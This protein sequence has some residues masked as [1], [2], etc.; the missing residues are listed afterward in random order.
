MPKGGIYIPA[1]LK[2]RA[3]GP[4][5]VH[6]VRPWM[7]R[8]KRL[9][10]QIYNWGDNGGKGISSLE[11]PCGM[12][13]SPALSPT[14]TSS[15]IIVFSRAIE[16]MSNV[17][18]RLCSTWRIPRTEV[19]TSPP[20]VSVPAK[21]VTLSRHAHIWLGTFPDRILFATLH[22]PA[23]SPPPPKARKAWPEHGKIRAFRS[24]RKP[25]TLCL[26][27][28]AAGTCPH[29]KRWNLLCK[30]VSVVPVISRVRVDFTSDFNPFTKGSITGFVTWSTWPPPGLGRSTADW[31]AR[32]QSPE[33]TE[34]TRLKKKK[35]TVV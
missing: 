34:W 4:V 12:F 5:T 23:S 30:S 31:E 3:G 7:K 24:R 9:F 20:T 29:W 26:S 6:T 28:N 2:P 8:C 14:A 19:T 21:A 22:R 32:H 17:H 16:Q 13:A 25:H 11:Q 27:E 18:A 33:Q 35:K 1:A 10:G 15:Y